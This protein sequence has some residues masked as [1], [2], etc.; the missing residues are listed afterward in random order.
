MLKR[1]KK[2]VAIAL[3]IFL[4]TGS[5][6]AANMA[7]SA[8]ALVIGTDNNENIRAFYEQYV[9]I[10]DESNGYFSPEGVPYYSV[11]TMICDIPDYGHETTS[12]TISYYVLLEAMYGN[13]TGDWSGYETAWDILEK[14][15]VPSK[16]EQPNAGD[17]TLEAGA[18]FVPGAAAL[19]EFPSEPNLGIKT[20]KDPL[21]D[22][23]NNAYGSYPIY[24]MHWILDVDNWYGYGNYGDGISRVS[25][26]DT[27]KRS[28]HLSSWETVVFPSWEVFKWG[29]K[30]SGF[31][32]LYV[33]QPTYT[34]QWRY[35]VDT[36]ADY[37]VVQ[38]AYWANKW[39]K[40]QGNRYAV[41]SQNTR[42]SRLGDYLRYSMFDKYMKPIGTATLNGPGGEDYDSCHY[43][44][45][46][47]M[48]W[49]GPVAAQGGG[50][51]RKGNSTS[52]Q[53]YQNPLAAY[54][55]S[56]TQE[57]KPKSSKGAGDYAISLKRQLELLQWLQSSE[58]AIAGG[59][60][61][62]IND[63]YDPYP[64]GTSTFYG[65]AYDPQPEWSNSGNNN[66]FLYQTRSMQSLAQY[67]YETSDSRAKNIL[68]KWVGWALENTRLTDDDFD[69]PHELEWTGQPD[70]WEGSY[71]GNPDLHV[72]VKSWSKDLGTA[73]SYA[74]LLIWY[75]AK[76]SDRFAL[77][78]AEHILEV[79]NN[80]YK[81]DKG[82]A[83]EEERSDYRSFFDTEV[84]L[85]DGWTGVNGQGAVLEK[86]IKFIDQRPKYKEDVSYP[87][88]EKA[89]ANGS[90]GDN[91][92]KI[93]YH[94][95]WAQVE[96]AMAY[97]TYGTVIGYIPYVPTPNP[98]ST[99][100]PTTTGK[101]LSQKCDFD[102]NG[103]INIAD[104]M[105]VVSAF[106]TTTSDDSYDEKYDL[107]SNG[108]IN[109]SDIMIV[110]RF[111]NMAV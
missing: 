74:N 102:N 21:A 7:T 46:C 63:K 97:A 24:A 42:A 19:E 53:G 4:T 32:E 9:K 85:P 73:A 45:S 88:L 28:S 26:I 48:S 75:Y 92:F 8:N 99:V 12:E 3:S 110:S 68:D 35:N 30:D 78:V 107:D 39:A 47:S 64:A 106:N 61:N 57:L 103:F 105:A 66:W 98:T 104:I 6:I 60:T 109:I 84:Y 25:K 86:G 5:L 69:I 89:F 13:I 96:I 79:M 17:F 81:D 70:T 43:L 90:S 20:G 36:H 52:H 54:A 2:C 10:H 65:M 16:K 91:Q 108:A 50:A 76:S 59:V 80:K 29:K 56:T 101:T 18:Q 100:L 38:A 95:F 44:I 77:S 94:R 82:I 14:Y 22:Q 62:S 27:N 93:K 31:L 111:F 33:D 67:Y 72:T 34:Q 40:E 55:L 23:L 41:T 37:R 58:G 83:I 51:W 87:L 15:A 1:T 49:G 11:E 71:T